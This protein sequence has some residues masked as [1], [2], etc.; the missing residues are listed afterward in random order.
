MWTRAC[1]AEEFDP[2]LLVAG[3][4]LGPAWFRNSMEGDGP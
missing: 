2:G 3:I 1:Q 4:A